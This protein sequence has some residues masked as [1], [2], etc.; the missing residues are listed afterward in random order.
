MSIAL[1]T[2]IGSRQLEQ[3]GD[4]GCTVDHRVGSV[5]IDAHHQCRVL[6]RARTV[7]SQNCALRERE[8][9]IACW[10]PAGHALLFVTPP[11]SSSKSTSLALTS[12]QLG[13]SA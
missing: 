3:R 12:R 8:T 9:R 4:L 10:Q 5:A 13:T 2:T 7:R 11:R 1:G 6:A